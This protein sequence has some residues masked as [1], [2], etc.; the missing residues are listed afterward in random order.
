MINNIQNIQPSPM[1]MYPLP[2]YPDL[3]RYNDY[4]RSSIRSFLRERFLEYLQNKNAKTENQE[5]VV[6]QIKKLI[7]QLPQQQSQGAL[8]LQSLNNVQGQN[9]VLSQAVQR[10][11]VATRK[12]KKA[13]A[14]ED[15][16]LKA[17]EK[18]KKALNHAKKN[19]EEKQRFLEKT[20]TKQSDLVDKMKVEKDIIVKLNDYLKKQQQQQ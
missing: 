2:Q 1:Y 14:K 9:K 18:A 16:V 13:Q 15:R 4:E 6:E 11:G 19:S 5:G 12:L 20:T 7:A 10:M 3:S 17:V 8:P